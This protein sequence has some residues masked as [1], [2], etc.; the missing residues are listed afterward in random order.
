MFKKI[1][2]ANR[3]EIALRLLRTIHRLG[4]DS[5]VVYSVADRH[6]PAVSQ[7]TESYLIGGSLPGES[8]LNWRRIL[9]VAMETGAEA[10][11]PGYGFLSENAE[12]AEACDRSGIVFIGPTIHQM[13]QF[14]LKHTARALAAQSQVPLLPGTGLLES[15]EQAQQLAEELGY[16][17]MLKSTAGGGGIGLQLCHSAAQLTQVFSSVQRLS[18]N[19]FSQEIGRAHV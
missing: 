18:L 15:L 11:H 12:F 5:V 17:V 6:T 19:N 1:L 13:R 14:G 2:V 9:E 3:G 16:P 8:Y 10:I 7:A 4:I